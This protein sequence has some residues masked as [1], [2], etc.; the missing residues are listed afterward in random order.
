MRKKILFVIALMAV[1]FSCSKIENTAILENLSGTDS[2]LTASRIPEATKLLQPAAEKLYKDGEIKSDSTS[3]VFF[4]WQ[5]AENA[6]AYKLVVQ[7]LF[8][9]KEWSEITSDTTLG[10]TLKQSTPYRWYVV[11][12]SED[13]SK[14]KKS[15]VKWFY[16]SGEGVT[17]Y[18]PL[19]ADSL[20]P[21]MGKGFY[22]SKVKK[23][24]FSWHG[25]D[26]DD[27][28]LSYDFYF[29]TDSTDLK[30]IGNGLTESTYSDVEVEPDSIYYWKVVT[31]D[32]AGNTT[33]TQIY[34]FNIYSVA[35]SHTLSVDSLYP[36]NK[37]VFPAK[38]SAKIALSWKG[39]DE[40]EDI[41]SYDVYF[42]T[43]S[44]QLSK[45]A[46]EVTEENYSDISIH[47][48][49][50]YYW[51][52]VGNDE[53][54]QSFTTDVV[55]FRVRALIPPHTLYP[56]QNLEPADKSSVPA[57]NSPI[58]LSWEGHDEQ[59]DIIS[60]DLYFGTDVNNLPLLEKGVTVEQYQD[61]SVDPGTTYY[62]KVVSH[63]KAG[64]SSVTDVHSFDV[65][66]V[67]STTP[68]YW[69]I[70][71]NPDITSQ[72]YYGV[73]SHGF[74]KSDLPS[75]I[76][77][78]VAYFYP[79]YVFDDGA[80]SSFVNNDYLK[81]PLG[82]NRTDWIE[83][84]TPEVKAGEYNV[85]ICYRSA[86]YNKKIA[87]TVDEDT[88]ITDFNFAEYMPKLGQGDFWSE[89]DLLQAGWKFYT[90]PVAR[91]FAGKLIGTISF[92][93][94]GT[95]KVRFTVDIPNSDRGDD[96]NWLDMIQFIPVQ[97]NQIETKF[98]ANGNPVTN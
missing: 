28:M 59:N 77:D 5:K 89:E 34:H 16:N 30:K 36:Q 32:Q 95:H 6:I 97:M 40:L 54:G 87:V 52:I 72:S 47:S 27:K 25:F 21:Q 66:T 88:L 24:D 50:T 78:D 49:K 22:P 13:S 62:W 92:N 70:T 35:H 48:G 19:P 69:D 75:Y 57:A 90:S 20:S 42:G 45:V 17:N 12:Q 80:G 93:K 67:V 96:F 83:F 76:N 2:S 11:S 23:V 44:A 65:G 18:A 98:D 64:D 61:V 74:S 26:I 31:S 7:N 53:M 94:D 14:T 4:K 39:I 33:A 73:E 56:A 51:K 1:I 86:G 41:T 81:I 63:D 82:E 85:W 55:H 79:T 58:T 68:L 71:D 3:E 60:Y 15:D 46:E 10:A 29:G 84:T 91:N 38:D 9:Q 8:N 37:Q 43:D